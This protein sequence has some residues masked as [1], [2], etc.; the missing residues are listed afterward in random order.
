VVASARARNIAHIAISGLV[1]FP[2]S[3]PAALSSRKEGRNDAPVKVFLCA[4]FF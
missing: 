3:L 2:F 1:R 4:R